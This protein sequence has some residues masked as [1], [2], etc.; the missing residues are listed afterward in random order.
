MKFLQ[1]EHTLYEIIDI[2]QKKDDAVTRSKIMHGSGDSA[3]KVKVSKDGKTKMTK[4][5][6]RPKRRERKRKEH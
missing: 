3:K 5:K 4:Q 2:C 6:E 1:K